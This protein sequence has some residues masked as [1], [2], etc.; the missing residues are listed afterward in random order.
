MVA[1]VCLVPLVPD[2]PIAGIVD[3]AA[4]AYFTSAALSATPSGRVSVLFPY[5]SSSTP[6]GQLW[7]SV[8]AMHFRSPGG[9]FL[10]PQGPQ[11]HIAFT[12]AVP[13][14]ADTLTARVL[15][16]VYLGTP[17]AETGALRAAL[18]AQLRSWHVSDLVAS[19]DDV[20]R[21]AVSLRFLTWLMGGPPATVLGVRIWHHV[22]GGG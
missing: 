15:G 11:H 10:V 18:L 22:P 5:P 9:Y 17:P 13:Y 20:P 12:P 3:T 19:L 4:P 6:E 2:L 8:A 7:Q 14:A 16:R 1:V 21:P